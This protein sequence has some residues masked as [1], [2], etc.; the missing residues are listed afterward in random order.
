MERKGSG[1]GKIISGYEFQINCIE[2]KKHHSF[3]T[4][5]ACYRRLQNWILLRVLEKQRIKYILE[6]NKNAPRF[7]EISFWTNSPMQ[8]WFS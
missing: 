3:Q 2:R 5:V 1:F 8:Y 6:N 4:V 7:V